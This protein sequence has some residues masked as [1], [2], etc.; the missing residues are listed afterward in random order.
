[1][2]VA[3]LENFL[4]VRGTSVALYDYA[5]YN[6]TILGNQSVILTRPY[7][8]HIDT[9]PAIHDKFR[10]RFPV[11][12]YDTYDDLQALLL[13]EKPDALY[14]IK[15]GFDDGFVGGLGIRTIVHAVFDPRHPHGDVYC[16]ISPWLNMAFGVHWPVLPHIV[17]LPRAPGHL[18]EQLGIPSDATVFGRYGGFHEFDHPAAREA[19]DRMSRTNDHMYFLFMNTAP[20]LSCPCPRTNVLFLDATTDLMRK[21]Q[22]IQTCDAMLYARSRGETFGLAIAEFSSHNKPVFAPRDAPERMHH[23]VL[24]DKAYWYTDTDDLCAKLTAFD[25]RD[26]PRH[27][28][29]AY[30]D[31]SPA[32]VMRTFACLLSKS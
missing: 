4:N 6:E 27:D 30:R 21:S 26:A 24:Q 17:D 22:F 5:H 13:A 9:S 12:Y 20:F 3:F 29:H 7:F 14:I 31:F 19:V 28:W 1:M 15:A 18:R 23:L 8:E 2:K 32:N 25:R 11:H 16:V 10:Q